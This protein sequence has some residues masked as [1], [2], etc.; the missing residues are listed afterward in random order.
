[1][2]WSR[3]SGL[4]LSLQISSCISNKTAP[5]LMRKKCKISTQEK[6]CVFLQLCSVVLQAVYLFELVI[7]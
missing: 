2:L 1:M 4:F 3:P 7:G 5:P 6:N